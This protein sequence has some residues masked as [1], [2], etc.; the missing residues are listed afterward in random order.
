M[1]ESYKKYRAHFPKQGLLKQWLEDAR[2]KMSVADIATLCDCSERTIRDWQREK[3]HMDYRCLEKVCKELNIP[4]PEV[5]KVGV[6]AHTSAAG[7]QGAKA[8]MRK[9]GRIPVDQ[10]KLQQAWR[11]WWEREGRKKTKITQP[12][13]VVFPERN[14][15]LAEFVGIVMGDGGLSDYQLTITLHTIEDKTYGFFVKKLI[16]R[17]FSVHVSV[18]PRKKILATDYKVSRALLVQFCVEKLGLKK[19]N[20]LS[21]PLSIPDWIKQDKKF[22]QACVRGLVDTDGSVFTHKYKAKSKQYS[23]K[24]ICFTSASPVLCREVSEI[25]LA[26]GIKPSPHGR[27]VSI[28]SKHGMEKYFEIFGSHNPKHLKRWAE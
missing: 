24:K 10:E 4:K 6:Y 2:L 1:S 17:L 11:I 18:H 3:F 20:K 9:Y 19:G 15:D 21:G 8:V 14:E 27:N 23:Y 25:L 7:Q 5:K 26:N 22:A 13:A 16:E 12:R 28:E